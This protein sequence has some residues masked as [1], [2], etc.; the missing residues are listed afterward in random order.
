MFEMTYSPLMLKVLVGLIVLVLLVLGAVAVIRPPFIELDDRG[1]T[2]RRVFGTGFEPWSTCS[3]FTLSTVGRQEI[4]SFA[5]GTFL[6][7]GRRL[8]NLSRTAAGGALIV[9]ADLDRLRADELVTL[10]NHY[11]ETGRARPPER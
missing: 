9:P 5:P 8:L 3:A 7:T 6:R 4:V 10:L 1:I 11:R 2:I